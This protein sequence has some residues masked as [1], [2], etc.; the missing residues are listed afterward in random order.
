MQNEIQ[1]RQ[2]QPKKVTILFSAWSN[3]CTSTNE[4]ESTSTNE[5]ENETHEGKI[6][7]LF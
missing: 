2:A 4:A 6:H 1:D 3:Q 5:A 7:K